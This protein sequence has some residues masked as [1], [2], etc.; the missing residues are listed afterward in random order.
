MTTK[1]RRA[2]NLWLGVLA[3]AAVLLLAL[4][5][6]AIRIKEVTSP[7][8]IKGWL[9]ADAT[10]PLFTMNF[11]FRGAAALDPVG[12]EGLAEFVSNLLDEGAGD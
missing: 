8:G 12:K 3:L 10:V 6:D 2:G 9:I 11:A 4:P 5:A 1:A 7:G